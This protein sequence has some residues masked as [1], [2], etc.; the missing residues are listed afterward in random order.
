MPTFYSIKPLII[1]FF[2][3]SELYFIPPSK[4]KA[5]PLR[6]VCSPFSRLLI[7]SHL[8]L[9]V[10]V[11]AHNIGGLVKVKG[12]VTRV[13]E[14]KPLVLVV[15]YTC[16]NCSYEVYQEVNSRSFTPLTTCPSAE[17]KA[18]NVPGK[19]YQQTRGSKFISF[20]EVRLQEMVC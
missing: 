14:V 13:T 11:R 8:G 6:K 16:S 10:K 1:T 20:Q 9:L 3:H 15:T 19:L 7:Y 17:C 18:R 4:Y 12:I 2:S 5:L